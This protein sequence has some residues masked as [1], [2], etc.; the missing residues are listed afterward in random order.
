MPNSLRLMCVFAHPDDESQATGGTLAKYASEGVE[1]YLVTATRG[2]R[3]WFGQENENPG[4]EA[5]GRIREAELRAAAQL[6]GVRDVALLDYLDGDL[7]QADPADVIGKLVSHLRRVKPHVVIT[8]PPD[9]S[10]GHPDHIAISQF[11][12]AAIVCAAD[13]TYANAAAPA[14]A[15][16]HRVSK[17]Y[18]AVDSRSL[19]DFF[20][21]LFGGPITMPVDGV[22]RQHPG[23]EEWAIT[24]RVDAAEHWRT[25]LRAVLAHASQVPSLGDILEWP[26]EAHRRIWGNQ[27]YYRVF[28][29]AAQRGGRA[30]ERDLFEG[31]R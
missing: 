29:L 4:L 7:D 18:Y 9:G 11:T 12:Q 2:E 14:G 13:A 17:L 24:T 25:A 1:T 16:P 27:T 20:A 31:L 30:I 22:E 26:E 5:L 21:S 23:W 15:P 10:Y 3:G 8:F 6:L 28:S 19:M